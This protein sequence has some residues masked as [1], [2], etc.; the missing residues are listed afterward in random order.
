MA[1]PG[2]LL[3]FKNLLGAQSDLPTVVDHGEY[4]DL[5]SS[6]A[7]R[8]IH[9]YEDFKDMPSDINM[10]ERVCGVGGQH[11]P[12]FIVTNSR[13]RTAMYLTLA[14]ERNLLKRYFANTACLE[15]AE[16]SSFMAQAP[17]PSV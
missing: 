16:T 2:A 10:S 17:S 8:L 1:R 6:Q 5:K 9:T 7:K 12:A 4:A 15:Q 3:V 14:A 11:E 13:V